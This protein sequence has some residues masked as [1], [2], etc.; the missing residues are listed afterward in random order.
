[1]P[2]ETADPWRPQP[3]EALPRRNRQSSIVNR[4]FPTVPPPAPLIPCVTDAELVE[5]ARAGDPSA[6]GALVERYQHVVVRTA[7]AVVG[8]KEEAEDVAQEA[9]LRAYRG[10]G[11]FRGEASVK[12]W[13]LAIVWRQALSHRRAI[14]TRLR[15]LVTSRDEAVFDPPAHAPRHDEAFEAR[16]FHREVDRLVRTLS[17]KYRE[18]L[19]MAAAGDVTFEE[20]SEITGVATGTLKWRVS[21]ARRQLRQK[22]DRRAQR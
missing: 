13:L 22:L 1:M 18:A 9:L 3:A 17:P 11:D 2:S 5:A 8:R 6:F 10:I 19:L 16:E 21:E 12:T 14:A 4:H 15:W 20:M 7:L